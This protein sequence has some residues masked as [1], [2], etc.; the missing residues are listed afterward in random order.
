M[1]LNQMTQYNLKGVYLSDD[2]WWLY[3]NPD[4]PV[5]SYMK[6]KTEIICRTRMWKNST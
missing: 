2:M 6:H 3:Y 1:Y 5:S 4:V